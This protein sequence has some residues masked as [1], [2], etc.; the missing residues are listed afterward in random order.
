MKYLLVL[1]VIL[2]ASSTTVAQKEMFCTYIN[3][4]DIHGP[5]MMSPIPASSST[6]C[7]SLC[8]GVPG[9]KAAVF[10]NDT[11]MLKNVS[12]YVTSLGGSVV[13]PGE[14]PTPVP[15]TPPPRIAV[16]RQVL[17]R[18]PICD[19]HVD[20]T[21]TTYAFTSGRCYSLSEGMPRNVT[22]VMYWYDG[23]SGVLQALRWTQSSSCEG[24]ATWNTTEPL[25][26]CRPAGLFPGQYEQFYADEETR[27]VGIPV[28]R[29]Q[30]QQCDSGC[31]HQ[32]F[33]S[34]QCTSVSNGT[35]GV[36]AQCYPSF[37]TYAFYD[38]PH[39]NGTMVA[40]RA[41]ENG[42]CRFNGVYW[43][44]ARCTVMRV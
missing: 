11:C 33:R 5:N 21:C 43:V 34:S 41:E 17:C 8:T 35:K 2:G 19:T 7:C 30:C 23:H 14:A 27:T 44:T 40:S 36:V 26:Q 32:M 22:S 39:C 18:A 37:V 13:L 24:L 6:A 9:C 12:S 31:S 25:Q 4:A 42:P 16:V 1:L 29:S 38:D 10:N 20:Q 28:Q 3:N 15:T